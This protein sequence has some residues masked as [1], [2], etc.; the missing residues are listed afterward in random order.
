[1]KADLKKVSEN[2]A[3]VVTSYSNVESEIIDVVDKVGPAVVTITANIQST[4]MSWFGYRY[5]QTSTSRAGV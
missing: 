5:N 2:P 4:A 3:E 1:M